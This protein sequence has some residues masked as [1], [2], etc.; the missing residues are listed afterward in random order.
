MSGKILNITNGDAFNRYFLSEFGG[1]AIPFCEAM[2]D[3]DTVYEIYSNDLTTSEMIGVIKTME[4]AGV[5]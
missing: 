2:M 1:D 5:K 4:M 3:G